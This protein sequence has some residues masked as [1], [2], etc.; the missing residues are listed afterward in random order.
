MKS[1]NDLKKKKN[2]KY[3]IFKVTTV[4]YNYQ[5]SFCLCFLI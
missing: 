1:K 3:A 5:N 2:E 4:D